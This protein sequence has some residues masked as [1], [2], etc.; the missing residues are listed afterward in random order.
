METLR[1]AVQRLRESLFLIPAVFISLCVVAA[2][3]ARTFDRDLAA[4]ADIPVLLS[5]SLTGGRTIVTTVAGATITVAALV[6][7]MTALS[8]Q[9]AASQYS[10]RAVAGFLENRFQQ[11]VIGLVVGTFAYS[12]L[13]MASLGAVADTDQ[14]LHRSVSVTLAVVLGLSSGVAIVA[15][16]DHSLRRMRVSAVIRRIAEATVAA[17][18]RDYRRE[19]AGNGADRSIQHEG[20]PRHVQAVRMGWVRSIDGPGLARRLPPGALARVEVRVGEFVAVGDQVATVWLPPEWE[21]PLPETAVRR[22]FT[23]GRERSIVRDPAFGVRQLVDIALRALSPGVN[24]PTTAVDVIQHLKVPL[25]TILTADPPGRVHPGADGQ[26]VFLPEAMSRSDHVHAAFSEIR[27]AGAGQ[28]AVMRTLLEV[29]GD[30]LLELE[31]DDLGA[32]GTAL[33]EEAELVIRAARDASLPEPDLRRILS[34]VDR[35]HLPGHDAAGE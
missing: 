8:S 19:A 29:F 34:V 3:L 13:T 23:T 25:R 30:L 22:A 5:V 10:P 26:R 9:I 16:I 28:P 11:V 7:S 15:Y 27:L 33:A 12:L 31:A 18:E 20:R 1:Y 24:D 4:V 35:L 14:S 6:F 17:V 32:R 2:V 21:G